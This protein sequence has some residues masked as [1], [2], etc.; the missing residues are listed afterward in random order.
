MGKDVTYNDSGVKTTGKVDSV[1]LES[2]TLWL[3]IG[4][5][6]VSSDEVVS[7]GPKS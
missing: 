1:R 7:V 6:E 2:G 5:K 4:D 3:Q